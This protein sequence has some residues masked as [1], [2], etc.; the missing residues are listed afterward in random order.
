MKHIE[1]DSNFVNI[2]WSVTGNYCLYSSALSSSKLSTVE[3]LNSLFAHPV[4]LSC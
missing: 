4:H 1:C 3:I 2:A